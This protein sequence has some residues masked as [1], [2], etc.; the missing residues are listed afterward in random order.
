MYICILHRSLVD[1][2]E[3]RERASIRSHDTRMI[4]EVWLHQALITN[5]GWTYITYYN[6]LCECLSS[7][8]RDRLASIS[9]LKTLCGGESKLAF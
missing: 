7:I 4:L 6:S 5:G 1:Q 2:V 3:V 9:S 8:K